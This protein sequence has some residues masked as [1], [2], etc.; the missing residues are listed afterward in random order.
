MN[1]AV[2]TALTAGGALCMACFLLPVFTGRIV[3]IGN[4][5]GFGVCAAL[6]LYGLRQPWI[7]ICLKNA[8]AGNGFLT[9]AF[10]VLAGAAAAG[11][12]V[13]ALVLTCMIVYCAGL[14]PSENAPVIVLGCEVKGDHPSRL[15]T[16]RIRAAAGW[17]QEHPDSRC[18]LSGGRGEDEDITEAE[19]MF[20]GLTA[21]GIDEDRLL[22]EEESV[23]TREN[24]LYSLRILE[25]ESLLD[26]IENTDQD[27]PVEIT[28]VTSEFHAC[29]A[30][31]IARKLGVRAGT[32]PAPSPWWLLPTFYVRELYG[33]LYEI[34]L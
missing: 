4:G 14:K 33:L 18:V 12:A 9:R 2:R 1:T 10:L 30:H 6:F 20:R 16:S 3:N 25:R 17:L 8:W 15:L 29:R 34:F 26:L 7:H 28:I 32:V 13:T 21:L 31:M 5:T 24:I 23:S 19:C 27:A 22:K 11:I